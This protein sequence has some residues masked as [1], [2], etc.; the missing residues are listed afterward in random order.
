M[1]KRGH[2]SPYALVMLEMM[3]KG[4]DP[5]ETPTIGYVVFEKSGAIKW[6]TLHCECAEPEWWR[7]C[8]NPEER[9]LEAINAFHDKVNKIVETT[10]RHISVKE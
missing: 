2:Q 6:K 3:F 5:N 10:D 1:W 9:G 8:Q 7:I 4:H